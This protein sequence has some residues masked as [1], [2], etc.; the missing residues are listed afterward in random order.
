[1]DQTVGQQQ[2]NESGDPGK[3]QTKKRGRQTRGDEL[4]SGETG[5]SGNGNGNGSKAIT[6]KRTTIEQGQISHHNL[7]L[8]Y[9]HQTH[10]DSIKRI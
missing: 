1:M 4:V 3:A 8:M 10:T 2:S 7:R 6:T 5:G 9:Q